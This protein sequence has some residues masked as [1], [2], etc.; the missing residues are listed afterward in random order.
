VSSP[1]VVAAAARASLTPRARPE[2]RLRCMH[3]SLL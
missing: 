2:A 1:A 3:F